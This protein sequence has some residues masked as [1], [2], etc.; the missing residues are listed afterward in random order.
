MHL[1]HI[2]SN[3][4]IKGYRRGERGWVS[5]AWT[6][7]LLGQPADNRRGGLVWNC[8][9]LRNLYLLSLK[10]MALGGKQVWRVGEGFLEEAAFQWDSP[11]S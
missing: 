5:L 8:S 9:I 6:A 1:R 3:Q 7:L 4:H 10:D 2:L 11:V